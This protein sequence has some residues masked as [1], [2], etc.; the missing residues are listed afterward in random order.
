M[1]GVNMT[2]VPYK[3]GGPS[4]IAL[5]SGEVTTS[6]ATMPSALPHVKSG[7]LHAI[8]VTTPQRSPSA[9]ELPTVSE[10]GLPGFEMGS[11]YGLLAPA[12]TPAAIVARLNSDAIK[13]LKLPDVKQRLDTS[14]FEV[15]VSTPEEYGAYMRSEIDKWAKVVKASGA[16]A[17]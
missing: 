4:V 9:P 11:W 14:G 6:F 7:K 17:D 3:G 15:L 2:H 12:G 8:A 1:A 16:H 13:V 5:V 10:S